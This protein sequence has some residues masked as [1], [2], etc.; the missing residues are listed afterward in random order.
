VPG[1]KVYEVSGHYAY[2]HYMQDGYD[3]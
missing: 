2:H 3:D 1:A